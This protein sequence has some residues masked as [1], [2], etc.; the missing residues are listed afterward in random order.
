MLMVRL[1]RLDTSDEGT[2]GRLFV[3]DP[4]TGGVHFSCYT[5]ELPNRDNAPNVSCI[6]DGLY[7]G[8]QTYSP[9]F[10]RP[11]Y[12]VIK[13]PGR[14][15]IRI[16]AANFMGDKSKGFHCQLNGCIAPGMKLGVMDGQKAIFSSA[17]ALRKLEG[18]LKG[19]PFDMEI[20]T[21]SD[22]LPQS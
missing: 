5:G 11:M 16:H 12:L 6:P 17:T 9:R 15:G 19:E 4:A 20:K 3:I 14:S 7:K 22:S 1:L 21:C 2:F 13:A 8:C 18:A 10:R